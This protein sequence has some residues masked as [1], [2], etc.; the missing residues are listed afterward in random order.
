MGL[1]REDQE[2]GERE[3]AMEKHAGGRREVMM[4]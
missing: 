2:E 3:A 4:G 1:E